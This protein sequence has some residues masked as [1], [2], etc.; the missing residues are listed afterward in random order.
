[1]QYRAG[2]I[3]KPEFIFPTKQVHPKGQFTSELLPRAV[4]LSFKN[5]D[6]EYNI[7][8]PLTGQTTISVNRGDKP[9]ADIECINSTYTLTETKTLKLFDKV[10]I[11]R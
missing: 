5:L 8:E 11:S 9:L 3:G 1:M 10:G 6:Y 2:K 4:S 7:T